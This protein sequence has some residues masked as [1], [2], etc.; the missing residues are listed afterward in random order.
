MCYYFSVLAAGADEAREDQA[1]G[2]HDDL[3]ER[4]SEYSGQKSMFPPSYRRK[5]VFSLSEET[6]LFTPRNTTKRFI[7][8][9]LVIVLF[10]TMWSCKKKIEM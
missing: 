2:Q 5:P 4:V 7:G 6:P 3:Q 1:A 10:F 8:K 9:I